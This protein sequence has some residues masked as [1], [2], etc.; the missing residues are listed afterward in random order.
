MSTKLALKEIRKHNESINVSG[1]IIFPSILLK[2]PE[3]LS[4]QTSI[5][6]RDRYDY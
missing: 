3:I 2:N 1:T 5:D 4:F 6:L